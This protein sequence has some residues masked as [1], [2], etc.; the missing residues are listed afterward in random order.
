MCCEISHYWHVKN[1]VYK[2]TKA[3]QNTEEYKRNYITYSVIYFVARGI[4]LNWGFY[5]LITFTD[6][7]L[8]L[9]L[10]IWQVPAFN[11]IMIFAMAKK[12]C[13]TYILD[14]NE[15]MKNTNDYVNTLKNHNGNTE[16]SKIKP[17]KSSKGI[18]NKTNINL[19]LVFTFGIAPVAYAYYI[20]I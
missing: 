10:C 5:D 8:W 1:E 11:A 19:L 14:S 12:I 6:M 13:Q 3:P 7:P 16:K 2:L 17:K 15:F 18:L 20:R 4:G 9:I